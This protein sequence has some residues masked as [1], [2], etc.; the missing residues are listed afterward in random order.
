MFDDL[1]LITS[2]GLV[3]VMALAERAGLSDLL[4]EHVRFGCESVQARR[5]RP[6]S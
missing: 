3:P 4:D 5:T 2:A 6:A 1:N